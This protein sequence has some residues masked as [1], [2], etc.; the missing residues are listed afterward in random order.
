MGHF[1][2]CQRVGKKRKIRSLLRKKV[3]IDGPDL[4]SS[5][6]KLFSIHRGGCAT[7]DHWEE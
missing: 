3:Y 6:K 5:N 4:A 1:P 7:K 2:K